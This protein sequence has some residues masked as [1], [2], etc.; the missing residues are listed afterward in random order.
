MALT[1]EVRF[2]QLLKGVMQDWESIDWLTSETFIK[3]CM[4]KTSELAADAKL[5][6]PESNKRAIIM[7]KLL[8]TVQYFKGQWKGANGDRTAYKIKPEIIDK[9]K[10]VLGLMDVPIQEVEAKT[11]PIQEP[12]SNIPVPPPAPANM[13]QVSMKPS[14]AEP[15][16]MDTLKQKKEGFFGSTAG[17][18]TIAGGAVALLLAVA[19]VITGKKK[20]GGPTY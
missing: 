7:T 12:A 10:F 19:A 13:I 9:L 17:K 8:E 4:T 2:A 6:M 20:R 11:P 14:K 1:G 15:V 18:V 5:I 16:K 3:T